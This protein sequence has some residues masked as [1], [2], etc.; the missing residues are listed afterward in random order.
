MKNIVFILL[1]CAACTDPCK[2]TN[3]LNGGNC[4][5]GNCNCPTEYTGSNCELQRTPYSI[6]ITRI[7]VPVFPVTEPDGSG[8]PDLYW[9]LYRDATLLY[10]SDVQY[11]ACSGTL[12]WGTSI[13]VTGVDG[14]FYIKFWDEDGPADNLMAF[15]EFPM[16]ENSNGFP[17]TISYG[18]AGFVFSLH[19]QYTF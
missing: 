14:K 6:R 8:C 7:E 9:E 15:I 18:A 16:Y 19:I 10:T 17:S 5:E 1:L 11:N 13:D 12:T 2:D 3:C 4:I